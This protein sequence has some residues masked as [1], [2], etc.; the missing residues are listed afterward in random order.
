[1]LRPDRLVLSTSDVGT[2]YPFRKHTLEVVLDTGLKE[3]PNIWGGFQ[4][5]Q[6]KGQ[7]CFQEKAASVLP[8]GSLSH[9]HCHKS[10]L[11]DL[12]NCEGPKRRCSS[13]PLMQNLFPT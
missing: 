7:S 3:T 1:M 10:G 6:D 13:P 9:V 11:D 12:T 2:K 4:V 8:F 5:L